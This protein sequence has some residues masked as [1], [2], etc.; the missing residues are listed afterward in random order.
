M[1]LPD[2]FVN[3]CS[4]GPCRLPN[5]PGTIVSLLTK[6]RPECRLPVSSLDGLFREYEKVVLFLMDGFG[7]CTYNHV[8][9]NCDFLKEVAEKGVQLKLAA[10]FP[11]TTTCNITT[12]NTG[13]DVA[14]HGMFEWFYYEPEVDDIIAPLLYSY[15]REQMHRGTLKKVKNLKP[16]DIFPTK[17]FYKDLHDLGVKCYSYQNQE[18]AGSP[19]SDLIFRTAERRGFGTPAEGLADM[20]RLLNEPGK[21]F[22]SFYYDR[23]DYMLHR[24]GPHSCEVE[25]DVLMFFDNVEKIFWSKVK[26][27]AKNTAFIITADHG[28]T[29]IDYKKTIYLNE[30]LPE[31]E[32]YIKRNREGRPLVPARSCRAMFFYIKDECLD[33]ARELLRDFLKGKALVCKT[34][35]LVDHC[36]FTERHISKTLA[37]RLGNLVI[38]PYT[39]E[40]V[41]WYVKDVFYIDY[42]G[43]HGG[44]T[45]EEMEI[46]F[47]M[48]NTDRRPDR[49]DKPA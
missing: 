12:F 44:L 30:K 41:W 26:H 10:Q 34:S 43:H 38:L 16:E 21:A 23:V 42:L 46:P 24:F 13:L 29:A 9:G 39:D 35:E 8:M 48:W 47:L 14:Q 2:Q 37:G 27:S 11:S 31:L 6:E 25:A 22:H 1:K 28:H 7:W 45:R 3:P 20:A 40:P 33:E 19:Y 18:F 15:G 36:F 17:S 49:S 32:K 5:I 4:Y